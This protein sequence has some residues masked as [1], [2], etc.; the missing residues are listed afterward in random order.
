MSSSVEPRRGRSACGAA[1]YAPWERLESAWIAQK[2]SA[3]ETAR[4]TSVDVVLLVLSGG[5]R[6]TWE[7]RE[8]ASGSTQRIREKA[9]GGSGITRGGQRK[10]AGSLPVSC[11]LLPLRLVRTDSETKKTVR[12]RSAVIVP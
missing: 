11:I 6:P 7:R 10:I 5:R 8:F 2:R 1:S 3:L 4:G 9:L 12:W